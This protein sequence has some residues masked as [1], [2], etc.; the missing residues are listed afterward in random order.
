M[1]QR[2]SRRLVLLWNI[3]SRLDRGDTRRVWERETRRR[4]REDVEWWMKRMVDG[5]WRIKCP[6]RHTEWVQMCQETLCTFLSLIHALLCNLACDLRSDRS[7]HRT[8]TRT[9]VHTHLYSIFRCDLSHPS[10]NE[11]ANLHSWTQMALFARVEVT[12]WEK[13]REGEGE[14]ERERNLRQFNCI[15]C[16]REENVYASLSP[17]TRFIT[18]REIRWLVT[19]DMRHG[20]KSKEKRLNIHSDR[21]VDWVTPCLPCHATN[22][23]KLHL[24]QAKAFAVTNATRMQTR[25]RC[26]QET[27][28]H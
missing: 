3:H 4:G 6:I 2:R 15:C 22:E 25:C 8:H 20:L 16:Q 5:E 27:G 12:M 10:P 23:A 9:Q 17:F 18:K 14:I 1:S 7:E 11:V 13:E 28:S 26:R 24:M 19:R 21:V